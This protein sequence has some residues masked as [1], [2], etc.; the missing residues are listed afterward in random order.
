MERGAGTAGNPNFISA[1]AARSSARRRRFFTRATAHS[2]PPRCP[3]EHRHK[4]GGAGD[5]AGLAGSLQLG[6]ARGWP[7]R[8]RRQA[9]DTR[10]FL[11]VASRSCRG[12][13]DNNPFHEPDEGMLAALE[14]AGITCLAA[15]KLRPLYPPRADDRNERRLGEAA[16]AVGCNRRSRIAPRSRGDGALRFANAPY[17]GGPL[18]FRAVSC[19][20]RSQPAGFDG[21]AVDCGHHVKPRRDRH[22]RIDHGAGTT[23]GRSPSRRTAP[24]QCR[25]DLRD[26]QRGTRSGNGG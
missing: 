17:Y 8:C 6:P 16:I 24:P 12:V 10:H 3:C 1:G 23:S 13:V 19:T 2:P 14:A 5:L 25:S 20:C 9:A 4:P 15:S 18:D 11:H 7:R 21:R 22:R 26:A